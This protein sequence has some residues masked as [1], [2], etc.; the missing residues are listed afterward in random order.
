MGDETNSEP[1]GEA[2][3]AGPAVALAAASRAR[4]DAYLAEQTELT[5]L[6]IARE[7]KEE[8]LRNW[9]QFVDYTSAVLKLAFEFVV[10]LI[11][12][13]IGAAVAAAL[14][15][16]SHDNGLVIE[17]FSVPPELANR[18]LT[19]EVVAGKV[20]DRLTSLQAQTTSNRAASSY[21]NNWGSD[22]KVQI[23]ETGVSIGELYRYLARWLGNETHITGEIY[24]D[25]QGL[26]VTA[27]VGGQPA[28]TVHGSDA[29]LDKLVQQSAEAVYRT[30]QPYRY[31]VYLDNH[32][33]A[34]EASAIYQTLLAGA[35]VDDRAWAYI[36]IAAQRS[37]AGDF[38]GS[39]ASLMRAL[40][41]K[42]DIPLI[43]GNLSANHSS[44]QHDELAL[45]YTQ[46]TLEMTAR[47]GR[48]ATMGELD[49]RILEM[50][51][52]GG[53]AEALGD[54]AE[55]ARLNRQSEALGNSNGSLA[56]QRVSDI[57]LCAALHDYA[58]YQD[59][60]DATAS[61]GGSVRALNRTANIQQAAATFEIWPEAIAQGNLLASNLKQ[62]GPIGVMFTLRAVDPLL[63]WSYAEA[64]DFK[65]ADAA[66]APMPPDCD[67]CLRARGHVAAREHRW[68]AADYWFA[69]AAASAPSTPFA[70]GDWGEILLQKGD[71]DAAIVKFRHALERGPHD[72]PV[73]EL[74]GEALIASNRSDLALAEFSA[75]NGFAPNWGHLHLKWGEA[76]LWTGDAAGARKQFALAGALFLTPAD[77]AI[78]ARLK[79][80]HV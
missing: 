10:A 16:A 4:A 11:V 2:S 31:A 56:Q 26:A 52:R 27:R 65:A 71:P 50:Q 28:T 36:G 38:N 40:A 39:N 41:V 14:W 57:G 12:I 46:K 79:G 70:F 54:V 76:L 47:G 21:V 69:R 75:A 5:R 34:A 45:F 15:N 66:A 64:G 7:H 80:D 35:S 29:E 3:G 58:C 44:M 67:I 18:G 33:R 23:P 51:N 53:R 43:Y 49:V 20:L 37:G 6:Q 13:V 25:G 30:T 74:W 73:M 48:D 77:R 24:R 59:A 55:A 19:G 42:P 9:S 72:F 60:L 32:G 22:I 8:R 17:A 62:L 1:Q 63:A 78:L 61:I 68:G